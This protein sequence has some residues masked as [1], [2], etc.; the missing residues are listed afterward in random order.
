MVTKQDM[1][2]AVLQQ[3]E[4]IVRSRAGS[5]ERYQMLDRLYLSV[6]NHHPDGLGAR[7]L[8]VISQTQTQVLYPEW[9]GGVTQ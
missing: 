6:T 7:V 3:V 8:D 1:D 4:R 9:K 2:R 5:D